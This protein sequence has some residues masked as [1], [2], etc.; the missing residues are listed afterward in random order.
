MI[1]DKKAISDLLP[2]RLRSYYSE[3]PFN[4][5]T[6]EYLFTKK[7]YECSAETGRWK[8][9]FHTV[10]AGSTIKNIYRSR[11]T[12]GVIC[13]P[14]YS[15]MEVRAMA[16]SAKEETL[17]NAFKNGEDPHKRTAAAVYKKDISE[18]TDDERK[19]AKAVTFAI[20]YG[21]STESIANNQMHGDMAGATKL[22]NGFYSG[23]PKLKLFIDAMHS[24]WKQSRCNFCRYRI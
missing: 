12:G 6:E 15:Q 2:K 24:L 18:V 3:I 10:P 16:A 14:D 8:S 11:Y 21:G 23:Y 20:L 9:G 17:L 22:V 13:A 7:F 4:P 5:E 1:I 19:F